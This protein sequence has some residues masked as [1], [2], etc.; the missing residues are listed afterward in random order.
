[1]TFDVSVPSPRSRGTVAL[2]TCAI[3]YQLPSGTIQ[4]A[5]LPSLYWDG[6]EPTCTKTT[7]SVTHHQVCNNCDFVDNSCPYD[8]KLATFDDCRLAAINSESMFVEHDS[9][10]CKTFSCQHPQ[11]TYTNGSVAI[12]SSCTK[13]SDKYLQHTGIAYIIGVLEKLYAQYIRYSFNYTK[14]SCSKLG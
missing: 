9:S 6:N 11:I 14:I 1:M 12:F 3:G 7:C 8:T 13:G 2:Y 4:R 5:C 10:S